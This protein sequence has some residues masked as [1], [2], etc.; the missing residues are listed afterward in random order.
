MPINILMPALSPTMKE[1][2]LVKWNKS[3][4]D[5][6]NIG[7]VIAEIETDK[8]MMEIESVDEG[9][10]KILVNEKTDNVNVNS[11]IAVL[12][13]EDE[14]YDGAVEDIN[15]S[16]DFV[17]QNSSPQNNVLTSQDINN[18]S[19]SKSAIVHNKYT[20]QKDT[21]QNRIFISPLAKTIAL[22][23]GIDIKNI[24][25]SGP[26]NRILKDDVL[27]YIKTTKNSSTTNNHEYYDS[28]NEIKHSSGN[29]VSNNTTV[30][31]VTYTN[32]NIKKI[33]H[34]NIRKTIASRLQ[35]SK[36]TIPHFYLNIDCD[37]TK[38]LKLRQEVNNQ[39]DVKISINDFIIKAAA[40]AIKAVPEINTQWTDE[41]AV[42]NSSI[43]ISIAVALDEGLITPIV[44]NADTRSIG[45]IRDTVQELVDKARNN[46]LLPHEFQGGGFT[47]S[48]L[49]MYGIKEFYAIINPPQS[50]ILSVGGVEKRPI[51]NSN[52]EIAVANIMSLSL[53]CD[54]RI[55]DG[56]TGA[57][58]LDKLKQLI[59]NPYMLLI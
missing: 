47:I 45:S 35:Y 54:H 15:I 42:Q 24:K 40:L 46:K 50:A 49:G 26:N 17:D 57:R 27:A 14:E 39:N 2:K 34:S 38:L 43:D 33:P 30:S 10:L 1:G 11:L 5:K 29:N 18:I 51:V 9:I 44:T 23:N 6:I 16:T 55:I 36:Q 12:L 25:G 4:G 28:L 7:D 41:Y 19:D 21:N 3:D 20:N 53:S 37:A 31:K 13:E 8:A 58:L 48:N 52:N 32:K 22:Q 56:V 59:Q